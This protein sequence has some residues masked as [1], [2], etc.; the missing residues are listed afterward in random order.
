M[1]KKIKLRSWSTR[2]RWLIKLERNSSRQIWRKASA[3]TWLVQPNY[4]GRFD[5]TTQTSEVIWYHFTAEKWYHITSR[6]SLLVTALS[7]W[8]PHIICNKRRLPKHVTTATYH[9]SHG[10]FT[11]R[12]NYRLN[13]HVKRLWKVLSS[14][15]AKAVFQMNHVHHHALR[16]THKCLQC[17]LKVK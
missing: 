6:V 17:T 15:E 14:K 10:S 8:Y 7:H 11:F 2:K 13:S 5:W 9:A 16:D 4:Y 1:L 3:K 12:T